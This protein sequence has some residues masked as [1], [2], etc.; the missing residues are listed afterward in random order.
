MKG[1][2]VI[3]VIIIVLFLLLAL[4]GFGIYWAQ[5]SLGG[6]VGRGGSTTSG[7]DV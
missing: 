4:I 7:E 1:N 6:G 2:I 5:T 3:A